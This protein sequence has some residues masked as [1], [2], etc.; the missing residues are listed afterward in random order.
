MNDVDSHEAYDAEFPDVVAMDPDGESYGHLNL[1]D[2]HQV[3]IPLTADLGRTRMTVR[4]VLDL[5]VGSIVSLDKVAGEMTDVRLNDLLIARGEVVV[6]GDSLN[7]RLSEITGVSE[8]Q[9]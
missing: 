6:I 2:L 8:N 7:V 5:K 3:T 9:G 1:E 4:D